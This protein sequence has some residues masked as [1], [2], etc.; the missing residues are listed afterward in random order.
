MTKNAE[1][2]VRKTTNKISQTADNKGTRSFEDKKK[3]NTR[4]LDIEYVDEAHVSDFAKALRFDPLD[5]NSELLNVVEPISAWSDA[6]PARSVG[7][8]SGKLSRKNRKKL[9]E[10]EA[11]KPKGLSYS[12]L[13]YPL[14]VSD[15]YF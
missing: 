6:L 2:A 11:A 12:I 1:Q 9:R 8:N 7:P 10:Q 13:R 15:T 3:G 4:P 14:I 5:A